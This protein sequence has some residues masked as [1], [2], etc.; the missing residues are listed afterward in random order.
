M[1]H[2][3]RWWV[4]VVVMA[5]CIGVRHLLRHRPIALDRTAMVVTSGG[6]IL[7]GATL[8]QSPWRSVDGYV[9]HFWVV[10]LLALV[11]VAML[12]ASAVWPAA[13]PVSQRGRKQR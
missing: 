9:G 4:G 13:D 3:P 1:S 5:A 11:S 8:S 7:A 10:Q 12:A 2:R 6:L